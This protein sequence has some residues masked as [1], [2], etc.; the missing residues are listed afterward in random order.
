MKQNWTFGDF[1]IKLQGRD[2][3]FADKNS[4]RVTYLK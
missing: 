2:E 3:G 1:A 4:K